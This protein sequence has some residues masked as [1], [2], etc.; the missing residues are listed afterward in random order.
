MLLHSF[1]LRLILFLLITA[2]TFANKIFS[3]G[4]SKCL[5]DSQ[6]GTPVISVSEFTV[7]FD[8]DLLSVYYSVTGTA[9]ETV[10]AAANIT[11][12]LYGMQ[13]LQRVVK[14]CEY[15][16]TELCPINKNTDITISGN[17]SVPEQYVSSLTNLV[18][19]IPDLEGSIHIDILDA[20][21]SLSL[22]GCFRS[23]ISN[24]NTTE[25]AQ[26]KYGTAIAAVIALIT[27]MVSSSVSSSGGSAASGGGAAG[28]HGAVAAPAAGADP[29]ATTS[30]AHSAGSAS[31][32]GA[33]G[34]AMLVGWLQAM[35]SSGLYSVTYPKVYRSF[36]RNFSWSCGILQ[37]NGLESA[38][39]NL[40]AKTGGNLTAFSVQTLLKTTLIES[41]PSLLSNI[42]LVLNSSTN[43][44][45]LNSK[46]YVFSDGIM[47]VLRKFINDIAI[48]RRDNSSSSPSSGN[49]LTNVKYATGIE[50]YLEKNNIPATNGFT[51]LLIW[52]CIV[53]ASIVVLLL[54][55]KLGLELY[56]TEAR[57]NK[58]QQDWITYESGTPYS[59]ISA[60]GGGPRQK[61]IF[62][63]NSFS[64]SNRN[65]SIAA[66]S[67]Q[68]LTRLSSVSGSKNGLNV[69][70]P[71]EKPRF[72]DYRKEYRNILRKTLIR[73]IA[74]LYGV[75]VLLTLYQFTL[76]D[77]WCI[78]LLAAVTFGSFTLILILFT[79]KI[80]YL[81]FLKSEKKAMTN[82]NFKNGPQSLF[83]YQPWIKKYGVFYD[84][85][86][87]DFWWVFVIMFFAVFGRNAFISLGV[88]HPIV[89]II[90]QLVIDVLL[91][92]F[93]FW[94]RPFNTK[95]GNSLNLGIQVVRIISLILTFL[96]TTVVNLSSI[97][98]T[99]VGIILIA[100][101]STLTVILIILI[102]GNFFKGVVS[103]W[104]DSHKEK[105]RLMKERKIKEDQ[106]KK[107]HKNNKN[108]DDSLADRIVSHRNNG[109]F[110]SDPQEATFTSRGGYHDDDN[111]DDSDDNDEVD[112]IN[113]LN[114]DKYVKEVER[115]IQLLDLRFPFVE[116][117]PDNIFSDKYEIKFDSD[118]HEM[119]ERI[120]QIHLD[121]DDA[122]YFGIQ[123]SYNTDESIS[124]NYL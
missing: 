122:D 71:P 92:L 115:D 34:I 76:S 72:Q 67:S 19:K 74:I 87:V 77:S 37:W 60:Q 106:W 5:T 112:N 104:I 54:S 111:D 119:Q 17:H 93:Y 123:R 22:I 27:A 80:F 91:L 45:S 95:M 26:I 48:Y 97:R 33:P 35:A 15:G 96:F 108:A 109:F 82:E 32:S 36:T 63:L 88:G 114:R 52:W 65:N 84:E 23:D 46:R 40:R 30:A 90:G 117:D 53:V 98:N 100:I 7:I 120:S 38:I 83:D 118:S 102:I 116:A 1:F 57:M 78:T 103:S 4:A 9:R 43:N 94:F 28:T 13:V 39:D 64:S 89:Q 16:V 14:F 86:K 66:I 68:I 50:A 110:D 24:G 55:F 99:V 56:Y 73:T 21:D 81:V 20:N 8:A 29:S 25:V 85:F 101:Q 62:S 2:P 113:R 31:S 61:S 44:T 79:I 41:S 11:V 105:R 69:P 49:V 58:I 107:K 42:T 3:S 124:K 18:F 10:N 47:H 59:S 121:D 51:T 70:T 6:S 12:S 75:W